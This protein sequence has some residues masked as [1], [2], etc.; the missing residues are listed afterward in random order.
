MPA[1]AHASRLRRD[2]ST[3]YE[4]FPVAFEHP[5]ADGP[6]LPSGKADESH[7]PRMESPTHDG[8]LTEV[9]VEGYQN[10]SGLVRPGQDL[11]VA[12]ILIPVARPDDIMT[13]CFQLFAG[14]TPDTGVEEDLQ[15]PRERS[16]GSTRS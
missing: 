6:L 4:I 12:R 10:A 7:D 3:G 2:E 1:N 14:A 9:L 8:E 15:D 5:G 11:L 13:G 16:G